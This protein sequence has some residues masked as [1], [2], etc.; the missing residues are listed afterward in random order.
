MS[1]SFTPIPR[2][3]SDTADCHAR[4]PNVLDP[5]T[6]TGKLLSD[7]D[8]ATEPGDNPISDRSSGIV[9]IRKMGR[10]RGLCCI[11]ATLAHA[12]PAWLAQKGA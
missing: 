9:Y 7:T 11:S 8:K 4:F 3:I 10:S 1:N 5:I 12:Q 2:A 6:S